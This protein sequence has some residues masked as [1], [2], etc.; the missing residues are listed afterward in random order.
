ML[1]AGCTSSP[2]SV[3]DAGLDSGVDGSKLEDCT[4]IQTS[5]QCLFSDTT[6]IT[7]ACPDEPPAHL[8]CWKYD[9]RLYCCTSI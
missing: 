8:I 7:L 1:V 6:S 3:N 9:D 4:Q 5:T 2:F